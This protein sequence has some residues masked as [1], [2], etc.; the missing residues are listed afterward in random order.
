ML[1]WRSLRDFCRLVLRGAGRS[2][3]DQCPEGGSPTSEAWP[4]CLAGAPRAFH[5]HG[6]YEVSPK[7]PQMHLNTN[8]DSETTE[9]GA[10][11]LSLR[12]SR[13]IGRTLGTSREPCAEALYLTRQTRAHR[14]EL[15]HRHPNSVDPV[16]KSCL[17][18]LSSRWLHRAP[19]DYIFKV[20][21]FFNNSFIEL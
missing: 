21:F 4:W 3:V 19:P 6:S 9:W 15:P 10:A 1:R 12:P 20:F 5:P 8:G 13:G 7:N 11:Q 14:A 2:L 18:H 17:G 16:P